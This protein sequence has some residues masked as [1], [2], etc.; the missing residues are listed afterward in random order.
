MQ[1]QV[2][3][4]HR[5]RHFMLSLA[6]RLLLPLCRADPCSCIQSQGVT[7]QTSRIYQEAGLG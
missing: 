2:V 4:A 1:L 7:P 5:S 3:R 6:S